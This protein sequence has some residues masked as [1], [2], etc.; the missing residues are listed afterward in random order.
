MFAAF[1]MFRSRRETIQAGCGV[2]FLRDIVHNVMFVLIVLHITTIVTHRQSL[3][4]VRG[5][6]P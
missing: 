5:S 2:I 6:L 4:M 1:V 3:Y